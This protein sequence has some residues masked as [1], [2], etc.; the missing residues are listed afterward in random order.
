LSQADR[1]YG[2]ENMET[3]PEIMEAL[4]GRKGGDFI[5]PRDPC[6]LLHHSIVSYFVTD[7]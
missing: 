2:N 7:Y 6:K 5:G 4:M 3:I 1:D